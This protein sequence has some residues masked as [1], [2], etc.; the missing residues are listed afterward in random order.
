LG[1]N[2]EATRVQVVINDT[3][4]TT[5]EASTLAFIAKKDFIVNTDTTDSTIPEPAAL[6]LLAVA[7]LAMLR[8]RRV[9]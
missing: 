7:G 9:D 4:A 8:Q 1:A 5:S 6:G 3:L 2:Q